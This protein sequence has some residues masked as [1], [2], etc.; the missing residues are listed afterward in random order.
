MDKQ[1]FESEIEQQA[2]EQ[3]QDN[4]QDQANEQD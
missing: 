4:E 3:D 1:D 2:G